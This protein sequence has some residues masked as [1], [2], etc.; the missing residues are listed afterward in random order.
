MATAAG[1]FAGPLIAGSILRIATPDGNVFY[2]P[3]E[4][5]NADGSI[6][7]SEGACAITPDN[8]YTDGCILHGSTVF[9]SVFASVQFLVAC[10]F[11]FIVR[12]YWSYND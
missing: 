4:S 3:D 12:R 2:C 7:C 10:G 6:F 9:Y 5:V 8:Y 11:M 1:R